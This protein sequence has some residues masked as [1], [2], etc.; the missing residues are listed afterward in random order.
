MADKSPSPMIL[1]TTSHPAFAVTTTAQAA[2]AVVVEAIEVVT[3]VVSDAEVTVEVI[4]VVTEDMDEVVI[5]A[6]PE[7]AVAATLADEAT[8]M[9]AVTHHGKN[10]RG[11]RELCM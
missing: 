3:E 11:R 9:M 8:T 6:A 4:E 2:E 7:E 10:E 1:L 5:E